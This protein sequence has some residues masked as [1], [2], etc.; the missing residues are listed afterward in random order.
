M[1]SS[2]CSYSNTISLATLAQKIA[3]EWQA[4]KDAEAKEVKKTYNN[5]PA[6]DFGTAMHNYFKKKTT[7]NKL[8]KKQKY[9]FNTLS[10]TTYVTQG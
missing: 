2:C 4:A 6:K 8:T 5:T 7:W 1:T 10:F 3:D 9:V